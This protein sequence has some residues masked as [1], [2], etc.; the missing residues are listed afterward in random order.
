MEVSLRFRTDEAGP[1]LFDALPDRDRNI[2]V[3]PRRHA[4][5]EFLAFELVAPGLERA[6]FP[7]GIRCRVNLEGESAGGLV[8]AERAEMRTRAEH[9]SL[10][11]G[12]G[13]RR[14]VAR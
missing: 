10:E 4:V 3:W 11:L 2:A 8:E 12:V 14:L 1:P 5:A 6:A 9:G 13:P 7:V